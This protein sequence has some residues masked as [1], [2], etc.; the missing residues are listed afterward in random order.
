MLNFKKIKL[1]KF[2]IKLILGHDKK[3]K[4]KVPN[5]HQLKGGEYRYEN[6][7]FSV[8]EYL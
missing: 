8:T 6:I 4:N 1:K 3:E 2:I 5:K 7:K